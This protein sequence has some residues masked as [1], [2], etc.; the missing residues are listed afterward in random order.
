MSVYCLGVCKYDTDYEY[1]EDLKIADV[2]NVDGKPDKILIKISNSNISNSDSVSLFYST[3]D[4]LL[5]ATPT[6]FIT[7]SVIPQ[8]DLTKTPTNG[9]LE[10]MISKIRD[11]YIPICVTMTFTNVADVKTCKVNK[12]KAIG[13]LDNYDVHCFYKLT[14][15]LEDITKPAKKNANDFV[16]VPATNVSNFK[17]VDPSLKTR[18]STA[19]S[20]GAIKVGSALSSGA[21]KVGNYSMHLNQN[22]SKVAPNPGSLT[23]DELDRSLNLTKKNKPNPSS[24]SKVQ[25]YSD[26]APTKNQNLKNSNP[27]NSKVAVALEPQPEQNSEV[28]LALAPNPEEVKRKRKSRK[29][30]EVEVEVE[31][32]KK[33]YV[34]KGGCLK[35]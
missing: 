33:G 16:N 28:A 2:E 34:N 23:D 26:S 1:Y 21:M 10:K 8:M 20:S 27:K 3:P 6:K 22:K 11:G 24:T 30:V 31:I 25:P 14:G 29:K 4:N 7:N 35:R 12:F 17:E 19:L 32:K 5:N 9:N 15:K 18:M 13:Y